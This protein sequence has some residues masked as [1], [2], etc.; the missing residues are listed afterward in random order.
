MKFSLLIFI[1]F[2]F[3]LLGI[4]QDLNQTVQDSKSG[5]NILIGNCNREGLQKD[6]FGAYYTQYYNTYKPNKKALRS[7]RK[8]IKKVDIEVVMGTWCSDSR[9]QVP[10]FLNI[11]D[12]VHFDPAHLKLVCVDRDK[13]AGDV[14]LK[15]E[16]IQLVPTFIFYRKGKELG[17][18]IESPSTSL[19][20]DMA[21]ILSD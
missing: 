14:D 5:K 6:D 21:M 1:L 17:R 7:I 18:I 2:I 4:S 11:L 15:K 10:R 3:P 12:Q 20:K 9:E 19:E 8:E 13:L 16:A